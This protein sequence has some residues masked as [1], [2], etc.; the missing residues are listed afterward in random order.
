MTYD[1]ECPLGH[2]TRVFCSMKERDNID[3]S[4]PTCGKELEQIWESMQ[5]TL[6]GGVGGKETGFYFHDYGKGATWD[7]TPPGKMARLK[8]AGII[9][10]PFDE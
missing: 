1:F 8:K 4:C 5:F 2:K 9:R 3:N 10:D 6:S 7:L